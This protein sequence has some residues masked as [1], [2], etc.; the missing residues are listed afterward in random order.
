MDTRNPHS[1][2]R[3]PTGGT[4]SGGSLHSPVSKQGAAVGVTEDSFRLFVERVKDYAIFM[5]APDGRI[6]SWNEGAR[7]IKG[8]RAEEII[9]QHVSRFYL[10]EDVEHGHVGHL[11]GIAETQGR[12]ED[13]GWR[14][15]KDGSRFWADVV[16]TALRDDDGNLRG[17][18]KVTR[19]LTER[20][21]AQ[22][23]VR[24]LSER[25]LQLQD[26]EQRRIARDLQGGVAVQMDSLLSQLSVVKSSGLV[27]DWRT[28]EALRKSIDLGREVAQQLRSLANLLYPR[29]LDEAGLI[30]AIRWFV[31]AF[32]QRTGIQVSM[33][34]PARFQ[35]LAQEAERTLFRVVQE[36]LTNVERHAGGNSAEI[37][38]AE[39]SYAVHLEIKDDG[40]GI[41]PRILDGSDPT[42]PPGVGILGMTERVRLLGGRLEIESGDWGTRVTATVPLSHARP[43]ENSCPPS[44]PEA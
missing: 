12:V 37:R 31:H 10:P 40:T 18:G 3:E 44:A 22:E 26:E 39:D 14:V 1:S 43:D 23:S 35:R 5:L 4:L 36:S 7:R 38:L 30:E 19:D 42:P 13:E 25:L 9:G 24:M 8:Y 41:P 17:F 21:K 27:M 16:I 20:R 32:T 33:E 6:V 11:L 2:P 29:L 28:A 15:R 34:V